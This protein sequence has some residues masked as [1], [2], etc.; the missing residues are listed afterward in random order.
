MTCCVFLQAAL[1][2]NASVALRLFT[3]EDELNH[4]TSDINALL[5]QVS[6]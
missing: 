6:R 4:L 1:S 5:Q 2:E 3:V